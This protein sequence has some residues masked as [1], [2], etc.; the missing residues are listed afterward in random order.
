MEIKVGWAFLNHLKDNPNTQELSEFKK[1][2]H[3]REGTHYGFVYSGGDNIIHWDFDPSITNKQLQEEPSVKYLCGEAFVI[4]DDDNDKNT[5]RKEKLRSLLPEEQ[6]KEIKL[7][8]ENLLSLEVILQAIKKYDSWENTDIDITD[9]LTEFKEILTQ[10]KLG[11][12]IDRTL[13]PY[14]EQ[15]KSKPKLKSF[16]KNPKSKNSTINDKVEF[17]RKAIE[18][19]TYSNMTDESRELVKKILTFVIKKNQGII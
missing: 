13:K 9:K 11:S 18:C 15:K 6:F 2:L 16:S 7:E 8:I 19:I 5:K 12:F 4:I 14:V 1:C 3:Y 10:S 17:C